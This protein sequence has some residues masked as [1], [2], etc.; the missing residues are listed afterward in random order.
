LHELGHCFGLS[1]AKDGV[2][3]RAFD[4]VNRKLVLEERSTPPLLPITEASEIGFD[5]S[6]AVRLRYLP[7]LGTRASSQNG[8]R[9]RIEGGSV[10]AESKV[11][12]RHVQVELDTMG[13]AHEEHLDAGAPTRVAL[14]VAQL[15]ARHGKGVLKVNIVDDDGGSAVVD[16][17]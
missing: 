2:M 4:H 12:I 11:P 10:V 8:M 16:V 3:S 9:A 13:V 15:R 5:R 14:D 6:S 7:Y 17:P 1:H